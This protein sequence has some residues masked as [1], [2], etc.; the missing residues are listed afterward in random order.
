MKR[1]CRLPKKRELNGKP[2]EVFPSGS[3]YERDL[4]SGTLRRLYRDPVTGEAVKIS[5][6]QRRELRRQQTH[7]R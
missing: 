3:I 1:M 5:K 4:G 7:A 6:R 2:I